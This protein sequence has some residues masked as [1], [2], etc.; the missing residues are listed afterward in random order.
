MELVKMVDIFPF[1]RV[2]YNSPT[3]K[4]TWEPK[5]SRSR[6]LHNTAE[7]EMVAKGYRQ[8]ATMHITP[9]T[10][11]K[12]IEKIVRNNLVWLPIQRTKNYSGFSHKHFPTG[13]TDLNSSA[14]GVLAKTI[15]DAEIFRN[16]SHNLKTDHSIIG[17]LLGF[18][19]CCQHFFNTVWTSGYFDPI[20]QAAEQ[21]DGA[22]KI[23]DTHII[24][25][26]TYLEAM[27]IFRY[28]GPRITSHLSCS[29]TCEE[30]RIVGK[31]WI[32]CMEQL[33]PDGLSDML[34]VL[35]LPFQWSV[36]WGI[37]I[38]TTPHFKIVTNSMPTKKEYIIECIAH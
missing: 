25:E 5:I 27:Q 21:T 15:E 12:S 31:K 14:Y 6:D 10:Y 38:I 33:D 1:T 9:Q 23:S 17:E 32:E 19:Q 34:D 26:K 16:A 24:L 11:E 13:E 20:W 36:K 28:I 7:F 29:F 22:K 8:A 30:S 37:A 35:N 4:E 18:P 2:V 3:D